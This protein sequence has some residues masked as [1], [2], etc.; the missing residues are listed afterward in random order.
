MSDMLMILAWILVA[1][2]SDFAFT[3]DKEHQTLH[4]ANPASF[5]PTIT[6]V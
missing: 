1:T 2:K 6:L 5:P 3:E 4:I